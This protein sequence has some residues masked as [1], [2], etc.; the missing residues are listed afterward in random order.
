LAKVV[1]ARSEVVRRWLLFC[2]PVTLLAAAQP[3][4]AHPGAQLNMSSRDAVRW[5]ENGRADRFV[6]MR[7]P[8]RVQSVDT[9]QARCRLLEPTLSEE[10]GTWGKHAR[11]RARARWT[12]ESGNTRCMRYRLTVHFIRWTS[13]DPP[14]AKL[15]FT[16]LWF[17]LRC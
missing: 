5:L 3:A 12:T 11:C 9:R 13:F 16:N 14:R 2:V 8:V 15:A 4:M 7:T 17:R 1:L 10:G 6:Y